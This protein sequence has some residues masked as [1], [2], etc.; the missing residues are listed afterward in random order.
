MVVR[1]IFPYPPLPTSL[2]DCPSNLK[3]AIDWILRVTGKDGQGGDGTNA[4]SDKVKE[5]LKSVEG[6]GSELGV[7][8]QKVIGALG[9]SGSGSGLIGKL[10]KGFQQ[11]IGY[12]S[13]S[14]NKHGLITGAGIAPSNMATHRLCDA[15]I[16]FTI[17][18]L[19]GCKARLNS[20]NYSSQR[21]KID[22]IIKDLHETYGQGPEKFND[23]GGK[24]KRELNKTNFNGTGIGAFVDDIGTA[25]Q[26][27]ATGLSTLQSQPDQVASKV[28]EYLKR[29]FKGS[30][31]Q[32]KGNA[33]TAASN[34]QTLVQ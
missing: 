17:G 2:L 9:T 11:F 12:N 10:A 31:G 19:E 6:S 24:M 32:G 15:T 1:V 5:L 8:I 7:D 20:R 21:S 18:V 26:K 25:F 34:L 14:G 22:N 33:D 16:A 27:L 28:G 4:L 30:G 3:E 23:L 13:G 29:V